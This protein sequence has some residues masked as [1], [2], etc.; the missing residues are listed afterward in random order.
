MEKPGE[1]K[2]KDLMPPP[3]LPGGGRRYCAS[4]T[5]HKD[6]ISYYFPLDGD[7]SIVQKTRD[8]DD[9]RWHS[10]VETRGEIRLRR[11]PKNSAEKKGYATAVINVSHPDINVE[12]ILENDSRALTIT[13]PRFADLDSSTH[14][15]VSLDIIVWVPEYAKI[16]SLIVEAVTLGLTVVDDIQLDVNEARFRSLSGHVSFPTPSSADTPNMPISHPEFR[17]DSRRIEVQTISGDINGLFPLLDYLEIGSK[18]G[19]IDVSILPHDALTSAPSPASLNIHTASGDI[20]GRLPLSSNR[21]PKFTP[22]P[23]NYITTVSSASG[24]ISGTYYLGSSSIFETVSGQ[25]KVKV[26]PILQYGDD[27]DQDPKAVFTTETISGDTELEILDPMFISP[28]TAEHPTQQDNSA[29]YQPIGEEDTYRLMPGR[30]QIFSYISTARSTG[31]KLRSLRSSHNS[32][33]GEISIRNPP[34]WEGSVSG[35]TLTGD[36]EL[37]GEGLDIIK[38]KKGYIS[39]EFLA[40]KGVDRAD[41]GSLTTIESISGDILF[42][43]ESD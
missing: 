39:R 38:N 41:I 30:G 9:A 24:D 7:V 25:M 33:S 23:R 1:D 18:S 3:K 15:C 36:V 14:H 40:R 5:Y 4:A 12:W 26:L 22:P 43:T 42:R 34:V 8:D 35:R 19:N 32:T 29:R 28:I 13:T 10:Q 21:K 16:T 11:F 20:D 6:P 31:K 17:F 27:P 2:D 37:E